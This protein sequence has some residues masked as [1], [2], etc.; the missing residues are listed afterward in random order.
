MPA[1]DSLPPPDTP[2]AQMFD[3]LE[4]RS[5]AG[6]AA[7]ASRLYRD[8]M[9]CKY[10][11]RW[12]ANIQTKTAQILDQNLDNA[13]D[14]LLAR[15]QKWLDHADKLSTLCAGLD[16]VV[17]NQA[18]PATL[19]AAQLGDTAA[20]DC[21]VFRGPAIDATSLLDNPQYLASYRREAPALI[22]A[23]LA[24]G[25]WKM[26]DMLQ[27]A[28]AT[29]GWSMVSGLV[30]YDPLQHY[31]YLKLFSLGAGPL[32]SPDSH[33]NLGNR[34][35]LAAQ[36]LSVE[37]KTAADQWAE[38]I[39]AQN[40]HGSSTAAAPPRWNACAIPGGNF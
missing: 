33:G 32:D 10:S 11:S 23:G 29:R 39:H 37:Q 18:T 38:Q 4:S 24:A 22:Q 17:F 34:L 1:Q 21:Y 7:A 8:L 6:D 25:D 12:I 3:E 2:L 28:Y 35:A 30:G 16:P 19:R 31:R 13:S 36:A 5:K 27:Y 15:E 26:V 40:F 9:R 20:R 14:D